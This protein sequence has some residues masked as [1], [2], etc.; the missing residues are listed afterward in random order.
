MTHFRTSRGPR[1]GSIARVPGIDYGGLDSLLGYALRRA[2][3]AAFE[4]FHRATAGFGITPPRFTALVILGANSG[5]SQTAL[6]QV[7][8][9]AR[10][11]AMLITD[12]LVSRGFAE[13]RARPNDGRAWGLYLTP[14]GES[15]LDELK[16]KVRAH[17]GRFAARLGA[18]E[19]RTLFSLL[20]RLAERGAPGTRQARKRQ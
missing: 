4:D 18:A 11:G 2:Q 3:L 15:L 20:D 9:I 5:L 13:R 1:A 19:R 16:R 8:G 14:R 10:S 17:D 6:G 7:L 12:W